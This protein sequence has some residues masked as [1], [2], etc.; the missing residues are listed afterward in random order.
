ML[1]YLKSNPI[2]GVCGAAKNDFNVAHWNGK[3]SADEAQNYVC[4]VV[5]PAR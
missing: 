1:S 2:L 5:G 4:R 3:G